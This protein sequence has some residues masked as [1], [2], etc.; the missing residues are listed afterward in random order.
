MEKKEKDA[1]KMVGNFDADKKRG[2]KGENFFAEH[3]GHVLTNPLMFYKQ[4]GDN[5]YVEGMDFFGL[6]LIGAKEEPL[7]QEEREVCP[8]AGKKWIL[9]TAE[10]AVEVKSVGNFLT[11]NNNRDE[12]SGTV[13]FELWTS[14]DRKRL[15][16]LHGMCYPQ[17]HN[18]DQK[19]TSRGIYVVPPTSLVYLYCDKNGKPFAAVAF[20]NFVALKAR[21][22]E[23]CPEIWPESDGEWRTEAVDWEKQRSLLPVRGEN[24]WHVPFDM[25]SDLAT[26]TMIGD[27]PELVEWGYNCSKGLQEKRLT[28]LKKCANGRHLDVTD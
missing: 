3:A 26:V 16:W 9:E 17:V 13:E 27:D 24:M 2:D 20:E 8:D 25:I 21:L 5:A 22:M 15:G 10:S 4:R 7:T 19:K 6:V 28:Y 11:R 14:R 23:I 18:C 12:E 1:A